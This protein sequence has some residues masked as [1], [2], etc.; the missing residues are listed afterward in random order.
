M[1]L[2]LVGLA[3]SPAAGQVVAP[4]QRAADRT[5]PET[6]RARSRQDFSFTVDVLGGYDNNL[7]VLDASAA[8]GGDVPFESTPGYLGQ[9]NATLAFRR[10][11]GDSFFALTGEG[12]LSDFW[13]QGDVPQNASLGASRSAGF[14]VGGGWA[15]TPRTVVNANQRFEY[16]TLYSLSEFSALPDQE[17]ELPTA[18]ELQGVLRGNSWL[19]STLAGV[20]QRIGRRDVFAFSGAY[21]KRSYIDLDIGT[22]S[23]LASAYYDKPLGRTAGL[24]ATYSYSQSEY[25]ENFTVGTTRDYTS[26]TIEVGPRWSRRL[27]PRRSLSLALSGGSLHASTVRGLTREPLEY[28]TP[29]GSVTARIDVGRTWALSG[30]YRRSVVAFEGLTA[31]TYLSDVVGVSYGGSVSRR[32]SVVWTGGFATGA[33]QSDALAA[34]TYNTASASAQLRYELSSRLSAVSQYSYYRYHFSRETELPD[35]FRPEFD[36]HS[37]RVGLTL[38]LPGRGR[39]STA[40][41]TALF[42]EGR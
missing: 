26:Q 18:P 35:A 24:R 2:V 19:S 42:T 23:S 12:L 37:I 41:R 34:S 28:W 40:P 31:E 4:P 15:L 11:K 5:V 25:P 20:S 9:L 21:E 17:V 33:V 6:D 1:A 10:S 27:S 3:A 16:E 32:V 14:G 30:N 7:V 38:T 39:E 36:R 29:F 13:T 8:A 22:T